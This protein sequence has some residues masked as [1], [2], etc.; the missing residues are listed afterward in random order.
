MTD[1]SFSP[2]GVTVGCRR[3]EPPPDLSPTRCR[4][5]AWRPRVPARLRLAALQQLDGDVVGGLHEGHVAVARRAVDGDAGIHQPAAGRVDVV[6][7]IGEMAE[8]AA[9]GI[10]V[11]SQLKVSS[12]SGDFVSLDFSTSPGAARKT[13]V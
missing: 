3:P 6:D 5:W 2:R 11:S 7:P 10:F 9:A 8:I 4:Y 12:S 1:K 13:R